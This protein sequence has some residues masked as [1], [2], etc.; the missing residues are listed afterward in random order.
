MKKFKTIAVFLLVFA[1]LFCFIACSQNGDDEQSKI[2]NGQKP[3]DGQTKIDDDQNSTD[4]AA[5]LTEYKA[6]ATSQVDSITQPAIANSTDEDLTALIKAFANEEKQYV[7]QIEDLQTAK[8]T[9]QKIT[10][11]AVSFA[12]NTLKPKALEKLNDVIVPL[13]DKIAYEDLRNSVQKFYDNAKGKFSDLQDISELVA[14]YK[15]VVEDAKQFIAS[16][17]KKIVG[18]LKTK[19][20]AE[21]KSTFSA[22][23][24]KIPYDQVKNDVNAYVERLLNDLNAIEAPE[25]IAP[26]VEKIKS[27]AQKFALDSAKKYGVEQLEKLVQNGVEKIPNEELRQQLLAF[28]K[29]QIAKLNA[30]QTLDEVIPTIK[31]VTAETVAYINGIL[32]AK[33]KEYLAKITQNKTVTA[34]DYIP[35]AM[36]P[37]YASNSVSASDV[38][39]DFSQSVSISALSR[40]GYGK[41]WQMVVENVNQSVVAANVIGSLQTAINA[42]CV[43][44]DEYFDNSYADNMAYSFVGD[45]FTCEFSYDG[46]TLTLSIAMTRSV[47]VFG[48]GEVQPTVKIDY[49]VA[50]D[51]TDIFVAFGDAYKIKYSASENFYKM[52][53]TYGIQ[54]GGVSALRTCYLSVSKSAD[55]SLV[56]HIYE[57]TNISGSDVIKACAD[58]YVNKT[59]VSVVGNKASGMV[60]FDGYINELYSANEGRLLGYEVRESL[61]VAGVS[62]TYNTLW[63]NVWDIK[64][65]DSVKV[66]A[67]TDANKSSRSTA[68]VYINGSADLF[69]PTYNSKLFVTTSRKYDV[70]LRS[71]FYYV[72]NQE[73][74]KYESREVKIPMMFIQEGDNFQSF[75]SDVA[76]SNKDL[77]LSVAVGDAVLEKI[78]SDYHTLLDVFIENKDSMS[79][80]AILDYLA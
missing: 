24:E 21:I 41:Q 18:E 31:S 33:V 75:A 28:S 25:Q 17:T 70:E 74:G 5:A 20:L 79:S 76:K 27:D 8:N 52:A 77:S 9:F 50:S 43:T 15:Q 57:Y 46:K 40:C 78:I 68:D 4:D 36:Q 71:R 19:A 1:L 12:Q 3:D 59:H 35:E 45:G 62:G 10:A 37:S 67:K 47:S 56:G 61:S 42:A 34:Y 11:D 16:E 69:A 29:A 66:T 63:F 13:I 23:T 2:D 39:Y 54:V 49:D 58:F 6:Q 65:I 64:G 22:L 80:Q 55:G 26:C 60:A 30:V 38:A 14:A 44:L 53:T 73:S 72:Y 7:A 48:L 32:S 51:S